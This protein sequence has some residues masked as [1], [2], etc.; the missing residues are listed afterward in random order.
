M[1]IIEV[2]LVEKV[3]VESIFAL[4]PHLL[5]ANETWSNLSP[6]P[7]VGCHKYCFFA[8]Q[9][10]DCLRVSLNSETKEWRLHGGRPCTSCGQRVC[11]G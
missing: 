6:T 4:N 5:R 11:S 10:V 9:V 2:C 8:G 7:V 3:D 1:L